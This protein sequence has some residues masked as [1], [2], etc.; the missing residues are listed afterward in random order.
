MTAKEKLDVIISSI[1]LE[2]C[3][4][5]VGFIDS[6]N[7]EMLELIVR[8]ILIVRSN[9]HQ[10]RDDIVLHRFYI[11]TPQVDSS[12]RI[13]PG[14]VELEGIGA[15]LY[16]TLALLNHSCNSNTIR[17]FT[18]NSSQAILVAVRKIKEGEEVTESYGVTSIETSKKLR[19]RKMIGQYKF[20]CRCQACRDDF[21]LFKDADKILP[22]GLVDTVD[23]GL[24]TI[25][26]HLCREE[27]DKAQQAIALLI[28]QL[29]S[30]PPLHCIRQRCQVLLGTCFRLKYS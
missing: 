18:H 28:H 12:T 16:P 8:Y 15:A 23:T 7:G 4:E 13:Q 2:K 26:D 6:S 10:V 19:Q 25:N 27:T 9:T 11:L 22:D 20:V 3:L 5:A 24:S 21:P 30:L 29:D 14:M 17:I 1:I